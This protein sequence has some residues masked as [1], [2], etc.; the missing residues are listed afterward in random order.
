MIPHWKMKMSAPIVTKSGFL[1]TLLVKIWWLPST[2]LT[3]KTLHQQR[4][5]TREPKWIHQR[6]C[7]ESHVAMLVRENLFWH[8]YRRMTVDAFQNLREKLGAS[9]Y[10]QAHWYPVPEPIYPELVMLPKCGQVPGL[11]ECL[12]LTRAFRLLKS[13]YVH[14]RREFQPRSNWQNQASTDIGRN[15]CS[16]AGI[17][18]AQDITIDLRLCWLYWW[19]SRNKNYEGFQQQPLSFLSGHY[20]MFGLNVQAICNRQSR[21]LFL[22]LPPQENVVIKLHS[23]KRLCSNMSGTYPQDII[24]LVMQLIRLGSPF[25]RH[26]LVVIAPTQ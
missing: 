9:I 13:W 5:S 19:V 15:D 3:K 14:H 1:L 17:W 8:T 16:G 10:L 6:L 7:R 20:G 2:S 23:S 22:V 25:W 12:W 4:C 11:E 18:G 24:S 26:L 21:F